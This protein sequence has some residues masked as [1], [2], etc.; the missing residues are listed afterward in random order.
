MTLRSAQCCPCTCPDCF[1]TG[2]SHACKWV[3]NH[4]RVHK[5]H[6]ICERIYVNVGP[7]DKDSPSCEC[8]FEGAGCW[9]GNYDSGCCPSYKWTDYDDSIPGYR[10]DIECDQCEVEMTF[11][12]EWNDGVCYLRWI[13]EDIALAIWCNAWGE[14]RA[15]YS[16]MDEWP[17]LD[18]G[19]FTSCGG[20]CRVIVACDCY[21]PG[22]CCVDVAIP[23]EDAPVDH[24]IPLSLML[25]VEGTG[26]FCTCWE[27]DPNAFGPINLLYNTCTL[28][29]ES[30]LIRIVDCTGTPPVE[31]D[32]EVWFYC[33]G[34]GDSLTYSLHLSRRGVVGI[35]GYFT[36]TLSCGIL[37][38]SIDSG[39]QELPERYSWSCW[40]FEASWITENLGP[41]FCPGTVG[42]PEGL[43]LT[44]TEGWV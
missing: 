28:R 40:P 37:G 36:R 4:D 16:A 23:G 15:L 11:K 7:E 2:A 18:Y 17:V 19:T 12:Y 14:G 10:L 24:R 41:V 25:D 22:P 33:E 3:D 6:C 42:F 20:L 29:W 38:C 9:S 34:T 39:P 27:D 1:V 26:Q 8:K 31:F 35:G 21:A 43:V 30:G 44:L 13:E 5:C 32:V